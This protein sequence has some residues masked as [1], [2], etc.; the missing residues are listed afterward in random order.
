MGQGT[1]DKGQE[2]RDKG[3]ETRD[4]RQET[5][6][7]RQETRDKRH[8]KTRGSPGCHPEERRVSLRIRQYP[9]TA[10]LITNCSG[11]LSFSFLP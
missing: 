2:T 8:G 6:D 3:Q 5:R 11:G 9:I 4:K 7:K 10:N 1:K